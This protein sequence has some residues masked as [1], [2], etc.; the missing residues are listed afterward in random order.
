MYEGRRS[1]IKKTLLVSTEL[2][3]WRYDKAF[4]FTNQSEVDF[5][6]IMVHSLQRDSVLVNQLQASS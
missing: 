6:I 3:F 2:A 5:G 1:A 4:L